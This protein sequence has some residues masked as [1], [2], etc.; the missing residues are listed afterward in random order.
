VARARPRS[1]SVR[2][3]AHHLFRERGHHRIT[4]DPAV[5]NERAIRSYERVGF[6]R[7]DVMWRYER[8]ADGQWHDGLLLDLLREDL[9]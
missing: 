5:A 4:I 7:V 3:L 8:G 2:T 1:R 6:R 9:R